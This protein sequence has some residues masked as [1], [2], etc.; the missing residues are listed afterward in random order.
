MFL[1]NLLQEMDNPD[2]TMVE[3][4][5]YEIEK[6]LRNGQVYNWEIVKYGVIS[7]CLDIGDINCLRFFETKFPIIVYDDALKL[8]LDFSS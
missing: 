7:W 2:I 6:A 3:Y 5:Q 8:E 1:A 4:V